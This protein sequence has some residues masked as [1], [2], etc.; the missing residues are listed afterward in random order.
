MS[1]LT[2]EKQCTRWWMLLLCRKA[3]AIHPSGSWGYWVCIDK[4]TPE[5]SGIGLG[6]GAVSTPRGMWVSF[7]QKWSQR[8]LWIMKVAI[9]EVFTQS[10]SVQIVSG[11]D[12][13]R[14]SIEGLIEKR[15]QTW[16]NLPF[17]ASAQSLLQP[18]TC[19]CSCPHRQ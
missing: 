19:S 15:W 14:K 18:L 3:A 17:L 6:E 16:H 8:I 11:I 2:T 13:N 4:A 7:S 5:V 1:N 12:I 10:C 9:S